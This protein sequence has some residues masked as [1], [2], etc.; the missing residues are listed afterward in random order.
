M[1]ACSGLWSTGQEALAQIGL[2][3]SFPFLC[4]DLYHALSLRYSK[5][6]ETVQDRRPDL[7]LRG[8]PVKVM[9]HDPLPDELE[10][11]SMTFLPRLVF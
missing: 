7:Q 8:L 10:A 1:C 4:S 2:R 6:R 9:R 3:S 11:S 5:Y